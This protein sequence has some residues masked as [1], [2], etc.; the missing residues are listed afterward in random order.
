MYV[1]IIYVQLDTSY[2]GSL[3]LLMVFL[4]GIMMDIYY[5]DLYGIQFMTTSGTQLHQQY[6]GWILAC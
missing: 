4:D 3:V 1:Y 2:L 6:L 5:M